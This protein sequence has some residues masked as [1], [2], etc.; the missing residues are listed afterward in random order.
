MDLLQ[1]LGAREVILSATDDAPADDLDRSRAAAN[2]M[3]DRADLAEADR[4]FS[5]SRHP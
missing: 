1:G 2:R 5:F 3:Y 4:L